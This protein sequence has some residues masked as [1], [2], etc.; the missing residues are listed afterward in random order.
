MYTYSTFPTVGQIKE[1]YRLKGPF[2]ACKANS[3]HKYAL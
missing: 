2:H 3:V 1:A